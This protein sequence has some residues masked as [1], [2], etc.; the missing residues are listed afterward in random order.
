MLTRSVMLKGKEAKGVLKSRKNIHCGF[1]A[2][3]VRA[4]S[5]LGKHVL[6]LLNPSIPKAKADNILS[7]FQPI[8][9]IIFRI[10]SH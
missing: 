7:E 9:E 6:K 1:A 2:T 8:L 4:Y 5:E 3:C 10:P